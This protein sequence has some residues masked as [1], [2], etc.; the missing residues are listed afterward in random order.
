MEKILLNDLLHIPEEQFKDY[1]VKL[2]MFNGQTQPLDVFVR[3]SNEIF[4]WIAWKGTRNELTRKYVIALVRYYVGQ[5]DQ[6]L[7]VGVYKVSNYKKDITH[8]V[9]Y[10]LEEVK[11]YSKY[12]GRL[13][14]RYKNLTQNLKRHAASVLPELE[15]VEILSKEYDGTV[16]T[17][18]D[19]IKLSFSE[20]EHIIRTRK[21][22]WFTATSNLKGVYLIAD[23]SNG[24][25]YVGSAYGSDMIW[26][27]WSSY[28]D[29]GHGGNK[30]LRHIIDKEGMEYARK[31]FQFTILEYFRASTDDQD[32]ISREQYWKN[33]L[34]THDPHGY[35]GN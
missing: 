31:N 22:D 12:V 19:D 15:I 34:L 13:V 35:N 4:K 5:S 21:I 2:N 9:G 20:L 33:V 23:K 24:K 6:W 17:G 25:L 8:G 3:D 27:R 7:F 32:I 30:Y 16:F 1:K 14:L 18:Y 26:G 11:E 29:N 10:D 28:I